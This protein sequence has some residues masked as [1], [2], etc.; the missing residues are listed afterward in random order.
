MLN[1]PGAASRFSKSNTLPQRQFRPGVSLSTVGLGG[2]VT[3]GMDPRQVSLLVAESVERGVNYYDVAPSY[4]D[5]EAEEKLGDALRPHRSRI[6]I[7]CKTLERTSSGARAELERS[8][9][10]LHSEHIDLYQLH[11]VNRADEAERIFAPGGAAE[12]F[13]SA[14]AEGLI[15]YL[16]FSSHSVPVALNLLE[17]FEFDSVLFPVNFVCFARGN[18]GPQVLEKAKAKGV[19]CLALKSMALSPW[20][21]GEPRLYPNCWYR[22]IDD[23]ALALL[24][25]RFS[26]SEQV[27]AVLPPADERLYR[28]AMERAFDI[29]PLTAEERAQL[30]ERAR[31]CKP[32]MTSAR[33]FC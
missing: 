10:R 25:L 1:L 14:R 21:K 3:L 5:G 19:A 4:G 12:A 20:R 29:R 23:P 32:I 27:V 2:M 18:F 11:S 26:L 22:P 30:L 24:A 7:S 15:R 28:V 33:R 9:R 17:R 31:T 6:F 16:G 13:L 8:L